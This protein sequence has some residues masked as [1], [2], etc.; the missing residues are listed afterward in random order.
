MNEHK[1]IEILTDVKDTFERHNVTF[2]LDCGTLLGAIRDGKMIPWDHDLD[3]GMWYRDLDKIN[4]AVEDFKENGYI[5]EYRRVNGDTLPA[6]LMIQDIEVE[7]LILNPKEDGRH[8]YNCIMP[9]GL[10]GKF[11]DYILWCLRLNSPEVKKNYGS[12]VPY[13]MICKTVD[14]CNIIPKRIR[15]KLVRLVEI[16][17]LKIDSVI[18]ESA[19][20]V[21]YFK[22]LGR[23]TFYGLQFYVP[24]DTEK[25][26][27]FRFGDWK[28]PKKA[29]YG[30]AVIR[31]Y[32]YGNK[33]IDNKH[34]WGG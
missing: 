33:K 14:T 28:N 2:W 34:I 6:G 17:Y 21:K 5:I 26:L 13:K 3:I 25:Y 11:F 23:I 20:P 1:A 10:P 4:N 15:E 30:G 19:V 29:Y 12:M 16:L 7:F 9:N 24:Y 32:R 31:K 27:E 22:T 18:I 8:Y